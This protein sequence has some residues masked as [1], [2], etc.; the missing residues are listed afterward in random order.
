MQGAG[1]R[2][3]RWQDLQYEDARCYSA[4]QS[5]V[6]DGYAPN[7]NDAIGTKQIEQ[8]K[9]AVDVNYIV[10]TQ[11]AVMKP[12]R[13]NALPEPLQDILLKA[14]RANE[15]WSIKVDADEVAQMQGIFSSQYGVSIYK[16]TEAEMAEWKKLARSVWTKFPGRVSVEPGHRH[17][18]RVSRG[19]H[20]RAKAA[21]EPM[22]SCERV[23]RSLTAVAQM[24]RV[25]VVD[26]APYKI[27][28]NC[29]GPGPTKTPFTDAAIA[30]GGMPLTGDQVPLRRMAELDEMIGAAVYLASDASS[31]VTSLIV[32]VG[33][34]VHWR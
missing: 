28:V 29:I 21:A 32:D 6:V 18:V 4:L 9:Y 14:G 3:F 15:Q 33:Q 22:T 5:R 11:A 26:W 8:L 10:G 34:S 23:R 12:D 7:W 24:T 31:Y 1:I 27:R 2:N 16:P 25:T 13:F 20:D 19:G 17:S 30:A